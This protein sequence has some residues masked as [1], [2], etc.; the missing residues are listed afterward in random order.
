MQKF[1]ISI[2]ILLFSD[3]LTA[4]E[5]VVTIDVT[6]LDDK[7]ELL[8]GAPVILT[9]IKSKLKHSGITD[10]NGNWKLKEIKAGVYTVSVKYVGF[11]DYVRKNVLVNNSNTKL[12]IKMTPP[13]RYYRTQVVA[14]IQEGPDFRDTKKALLYSNGGTSLYLFSDSTYKI[15]TIGHGVVGIG[16]CTTYGKYT[17]TGDSLF[18]RTRLFAKRPITL[19]VDTLHR[20]EKVNLL[21]VKGRKILRK[22]EMY[23]ENSKA[24]IEGLAE[25]V[26][27]SLYHESATATFKNPF[28]C[29]LSIG[30]EEA[31]AP[32][33]S[34][35]YYVPRSR[36]KE[37]NLRF[38]QLPYKMKE[39][40]TYS[41]K[42]ENDKLIIND[43]HKDLLQRPLVRKY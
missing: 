41:F 25:G 35:I 32:K 29:F 22:E 8:I 18:L 1:I 28:N 7:N 39:V 30:F 3:K 36:K 6:I 5:A 23:F 9:N 31:V 12:V 33:I 24:F 13:H 15:T 14:G 34:Y 21:S 2:I 42:V 20:Y 38:H 26:S 17:F 37:L 27:D 43:K 16:A 10:F 4:Q 11:E 40:P 19:V